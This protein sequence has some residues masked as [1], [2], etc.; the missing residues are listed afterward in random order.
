MDLGPAS[1]DAGRLNPNSIRR[2][3]SAARNRFDVV[4]IDTGPVPS[5]LEAS[6]MAAESEGVVLTVA[7]GEERPMAARAKRHLESIGATVLG[8]VFNRAGH[9]DLEPYSYRPHSISGDKQLG[10]A[11]RRNLS[12]RR[13]RQTNQFGPV[14]QA[15]SFYAPEGNGKSNGAGRNSTENRPT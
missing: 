11:K 6:L 7:R 2:L 9:R 15:V 1:D 13:D 4:L 8:V 5:S 14:A 10:E 12:S 3:L